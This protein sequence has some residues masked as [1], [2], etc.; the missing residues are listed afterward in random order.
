MKIIEFPTN[1]SQSIGRQVEES[2]LG[3][4]QECS[5]VDGPN[6]V[7]GQIQQTQQGQIHERQLGK[8]LESIVVQVQSHQHTE[9]AKG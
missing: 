2:Q 8:R 1:F 3:S 4:I 9:T 7:G 6:L 5:S